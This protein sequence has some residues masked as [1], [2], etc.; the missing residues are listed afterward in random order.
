MVQEGR[1]YFDSVDNEVPDKLLEMLIVLPAYFITGPWNIYKIKIPEFSE[2][3][4]KYWYLA[5]KVKDVSAFDLKEI[6]DIYK[7]SLR[8]MS[9]EEINKYNKTVDVDFI[10]E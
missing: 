1:S 10:L 3:A 4:E 7:E 2:I 8:E 9:D 6:K 5:D